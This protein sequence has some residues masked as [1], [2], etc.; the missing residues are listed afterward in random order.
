MRRDELPVD[1]TA[2]HHAR[3][4]YEEL[5]GWSEDITGV[6]SFADLPPAAQRYVLAL[7]EMSG[8]RISG[9]GVGAGRDATIVRHDLLS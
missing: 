8:T 3:P 9:I 1:Q 6:R 7:E 4:V 2:F 5:A